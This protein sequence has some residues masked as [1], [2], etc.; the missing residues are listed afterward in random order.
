MTRSFV[1]NL[2]L[3]VVVLAAALVGYNYF[4]GTPE[5]Q[6]DSRE[7]IAQV[8]GLTS[9][10]F[11]LLQS[12][13]GKYQEG[14]YDDALAKMKETFAL[15]REKATAAGASGREVLNRL[16]ELE[17]QELELESQLSSLGGSG[18]GQ[19][20][21]IVPLGP[22]GLPSADESGQLKTAEAIRQQLLR[23]NQQAEELSLQLGP[24]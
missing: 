4:W 17:R 14:K 9:S 13:A 5:E 21:R 22:D 24:S 18:G 16:A 20:M 3:L 2:I 15:L 10:V 1:R 11:N 8:K 6:E 7:I 19:A 12:E 23:L